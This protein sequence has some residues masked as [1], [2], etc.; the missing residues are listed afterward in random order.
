M[1]I[2]SL[3]KN[4]DAP[5]FFMANMYV[6]NNLVIERLSKLVAIHKVNYDPMLPQISTIP[7]HDLQSVFTWRHADH[8]GVPKQ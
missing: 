1:I 6:N 4:Q 8:I 2:F 7:A 3:A 5:W